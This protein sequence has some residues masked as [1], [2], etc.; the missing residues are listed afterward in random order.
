MG[1]RNERRV[2]LWGYLGAG[3]SH[4]AARLRA[5]G[6]TDVVEM[7][8]LDVPGTSTPA[9]AVILTVLDGVNLVACLDDPAV[10]PLIRAQI[11]AADALFISRADVADVSPAARMLVDS[12]SARL[13]SAE[14]DAALAEAVSTLKPPEAARQSTMPS[15]SKYAQWT[16]RGPA[17]LTGDA[18]EQF[19]ANRPKGAYRIRG[20]VR[21]ASKGVDVQVFGRGR[22]LAPIAQ[23]EET[24]LSATGLASRFSVAE[25]DLAFSSAV[26]AASYGRGVI[27]CR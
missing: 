14:T 24:V 18:L 1:S 12:E 17:V 19:F 2:V 10:R 21:G 20:E 27:A 7:G 6:L 16:Y 3:K 8:A 13:L 5:S 11:D 15:S 26:V 25:M 22:Q 4:L 23:P 9:E